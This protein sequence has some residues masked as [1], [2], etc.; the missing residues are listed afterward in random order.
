MSG[1]TL[2]SM[3]EADHRLRAHELIVR[4]QKKLHRDAE[5]W[6]KYEA[7]ID[8]AAETAAQRREDSGSE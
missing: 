4:N 1:M 7:E 6:R 3:V 2:G 8:K 5:V